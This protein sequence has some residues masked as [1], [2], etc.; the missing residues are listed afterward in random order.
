VREGY[1]SLER[2]LSIYGVVIEGGKA[3]PIATEAQRRK[4]AALRQYFRIEASVED[5]F[6]TNGLRL[7]PMSPQAAALLGAKEGSLVEY[8]SPASAPLR[9]WVTLV[10]NA[11]ADTLSLGPMGLGIL[12]VQ[13]GE[14]VQLRLL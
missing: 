14:R 6:D 5:T 3:D 10:A 12:R 11:K 2:A 9:A 8:L 13:P 1:V 4:L 7:C